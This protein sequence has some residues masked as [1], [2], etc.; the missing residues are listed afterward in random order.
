MKTQKKHTGLAVCLFVCCVFAFCLAG[1]YIYQVGKLTESGYL[2][3]EYKKEIAKKSADNIAVQDYFVELSELEN[4]LALAG[5]VPSG[6]IIFVSL[7]QKRL[8]RAGF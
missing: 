5:F 3:K 6:D 2:A 1:F 8:S 7:A 4:E